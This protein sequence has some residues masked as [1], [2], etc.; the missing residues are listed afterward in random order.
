MKSVEANLAGLLSLTYDEYRNTCAHWQPPIPVEIFP[1]ADDYL[2]ATSKKCDRFDYLMTKYLYQ[3]DSYNLFFK[4]FKR[5][6]IYLEKNAGIKIKRILDF[7]LLYD[8]LNVEKMRFKQYINIKI[9]KKSVYIL[10]DC[11][12]SLPDWA[13]RVMELGGDFEQITLYWYQMHT[14]TNDMK[15]FKAG[16]LLKEILDRFRGKIQ[17]N[18][19]SNVSLWMHFAHDITIVNVLKSLGMYEVQIF[20]TS[21]NRIFP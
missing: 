21:F 17:L 10:C 13:E 11:L 3:N 14:G 16:F 19:S 12:F 4:R 8:T 7:V 6:I 20:L 1:A 5:L 15:K 2:L 9:P 18:Q